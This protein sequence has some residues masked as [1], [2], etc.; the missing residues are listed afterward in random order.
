MKV[1]IIEDEI[2]AFEELKRML[3]RIDEDIEISAHFKSIKELLAGYSLHLF[4]LV[5]CDINLPDGKTFS[6]LDQIIKETPIIFTTAYD[7]YAI[8]AFKYNS[9]DYLL[10]PFT[11]TELK[12][13]LSKYHTRISKTQINVDEIQRLLKVEHKSPKRKRLLVKIGD[14][15]M[16]LNT[17]TIAYFYAEDKVTFA[18]TFSNKKY[19]IEESLSDL[20]NSLDNTFYR[21]S[22]SMICSVEA[23]ESASKYFNSRL[24]L[25][26]N[27]PFDKQVLISRVKVND[28]LEWLNS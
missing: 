1:A 27:P 11:E 25:Q 16:Y 4:D 15:F 21:I 20:E 7:E 2:Y 12:K 5:F 13:A 19:L 17:D 14:K 18:K 3:Y 23:V 8:K 9:V 24:L 26:L 28:F 22:R 10:K 6:V